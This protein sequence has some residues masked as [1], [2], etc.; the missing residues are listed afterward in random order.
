MCDKPA[1]TLDIDVYQL[2]LSCHVRT[3]VSEELLKLT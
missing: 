2:V 3:I 1:L